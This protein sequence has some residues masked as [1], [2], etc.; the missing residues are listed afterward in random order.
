MPH[1]NASVKSTP[2]LFSS[3]YSRSASRE[4]GALLFTMASPMDNDLARIK[5]GWFGVADSLPH[6]VLHTHKAQKAQKGKFDAVQ[7][8]ALADSGFAMPVL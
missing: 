3:S 5:V 4:A 2:L 7:R 1:I 8:D 6:N